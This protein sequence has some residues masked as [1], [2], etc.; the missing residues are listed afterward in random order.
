MLTPE[1]GAQWVRYREP[2]T[3]N[4]YLSERLST[5]FRYLFPLDHVPEKAILTLR[6]MK[7]AEV[8][9]NGSLLATSRRDPKQ[10]KEPYRVDLVTSLEMKYFL[11]A[12][13]Y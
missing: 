9:L 4:A 2:F 3:L 8:Y 6:A 10:W 11:T 7:M 5:T 1:G 13:E 12:K